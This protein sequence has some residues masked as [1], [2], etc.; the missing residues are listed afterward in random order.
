MKAMIARLL[1]WLLAKLEAPAP[2]DAAEVWAVV[3]QAYADVGGNPEAIGPGFDLAASGKLYEV[4]NL[5]G[6]RLGKDHELRT[7]D[8]VVDWLM[9]APKKS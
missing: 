1:S 9:E 5:S 6:V 7:A 8:D 2:S 3:R 4:L